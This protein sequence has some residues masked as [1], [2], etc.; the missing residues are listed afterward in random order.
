MKKKKKWVS[1]QALQPKRSERNTHWSLEICAFLA[2]VLGIW[3]VFHSFAESFFVE[4]SSIYLWMMIVSVCLLSGFIVKVTMKNWIPIVLGLCICL[5]LVFMSNEMLL[6]QWKF[7][8]ELILSEIKIYFG[9]YGN[10]SVYQKPS[11]MWTF[12]CIVSI[13]YGIVLTPCFYQRRTGLAAV[14]LLLE[15][16]LAS[17]IGKMPSVSSGICLILSIA[18]LRM[19]E[20]MEQTFRDKKYQIRRLLE[21]ILIFTICMGAAWFAHGTV[22]EWFSNNKQIYYSFRTS[23]HD[24]DIE[25]LAQSMIN[26][27]GMYFPA[28][29]GNAGGIFNRSGKVQ[30]SGEVHL[31]I[32]CE[33]DLNQ[34]LYIKGYAASKYTSQGWKVAENF[35][36]YSRTIC[37]GLFNTGFLITSNY[38]IQDYLV[39]DESSLNYNIISVR[40]VGANQHFQ[41][42][43]YYSYLDE[44]EN[45]IL[46]EDAYIEAAN[47]KEKEYLVMVYDIEQCSM[48]L[49]RWL[50]KMA[51]DTADFTPFYIR[52]VH[53]QNLEI[54]EGVMESTI[55]KFRTKAKYEYISYSKAIAL[56]REELS[57][58][59]YSTEALSVPLGA[60]PVDYFMNESKEGYCVYFAS[61][62]T[63]M[64]RA[65]GI[66]ARY[67]E[68]YVLQESVKAG[69]T[70]DVTDASAHAWVE[71]FDDQFGWIPVE[72]TVGYYEKDI[73]ADE[74]ENTIEEVEESTDETEESEE[75]IEKETTESTN[76]VIEAEENSAEESLK[77]NFP[78]SQSQDLS[79]H[80]SGPGGSKG[81]EI[82]SYQNL[83]N[84]LVL[85]IL[86]VLC[87]LSSW[88]IL[89]WRVHVCEVRRNRWI[90]QKNQRK[91][92]LSLFRQIKRLCSYSG[93]QVD[94]YT[95]NFTDAFPFVKSEQFEHVC[96]IVIK[97]MFSREPITR[98]E[99]EVVL[100]L[101]YLIEAEIINERFIVNNKNA[102]LQWIRWK[103]NQ[104]RYYIL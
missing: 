85:I 29:A 74:T 90:R 10:V 20:C 75:S 14:I 15:V 36:A 44:E 104:I 101:Y 4:Y 89:L 33:E 28:Q 100:D 50:H 49:D 54:P 47:T 77:S 9:G 98:Q 86:G 96:E 58:Y 3:G 38:H 11:S 84:Y 76:D 67:A 82:D 73:L 2:E 13:L 21:S 55:T 70:V 23:L 93:A 92:V 71:I 56:V 57:D 37:L 52:W 102:V 99:A 79:S 18:I 26:R 103:W 46:I 53:E 63:L 59:K 42:V 68:G 24:M 48:N 60:D 81:T 7:V 78:F 12:W 27:L 16:L 88:Y 35:P 31:Q 1:I 83:R 34:S 25:E 95:E 8:A 30:Y 40:N 5:L 17:I 51:D 64:F 66:P 97:A 41:Y 94:E 80:G 91:K 6:R 61:A 32:T 43:P 65:L 19:V 45:G 87:M 69:E 62:A 39:S 22:Y 72:V